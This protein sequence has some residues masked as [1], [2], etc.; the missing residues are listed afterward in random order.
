M[1]ERVYI[2][3][4][5]SHGGKLGWFARFRNYRKHRQ[6]AKWIE[7]Q[8][9][10]ACSPIVEMAPADLLGLNLF[11]QELYMIASHGLLRCCD[12]IY[13]IDKWYLSENCQKEA[14]WAKE[15]GIEDF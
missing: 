13:K 1:N 3:G 14:R 15:W 4:A 5:Y 8:G 7:S 2:C 6:I 10:I 9:Y 11:G 12:K